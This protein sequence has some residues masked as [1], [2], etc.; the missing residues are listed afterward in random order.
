[1]M[2][3]IRI[4]LI[5]AIS[6]VMVGCLPH[7]Y[8]NR[9]RHPDY[10]SNYHYSYAKEPS[11]SQPAGRWVRL[12]ECIGP[13]TFCSFPAGSRE[14]ATCVEVEEE[15]WEGG[16]TWKLEEE[17]GAEDTE[18]V[19]EKLNEEVD[20]VMEEGMEVELDL[21]DTQEGAEPDIEA[22]EA[23]NSGSK[24]SLTSEDDEA[25]QGEEEV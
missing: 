23:D 10:Y 25:I 17:E 2:A 24:T 5:F 14:Q 13:R 11:Y 21:E 12:V 18:D 15:C 22:V 16:Y 8:S 20:E 9:H 7:Y 4:L 3:S 1:M 6:L 19:V